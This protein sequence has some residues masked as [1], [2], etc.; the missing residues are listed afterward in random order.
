MYDIDSNFEDLI[1]GEK[2]FLKRGWLWV[3]NELELS[4]LN[5]IR[6]MLKKDIN[7]LIDEAES[8][9]LNVL[10]R[11]FIFAVDKLRELDKVRPES[12]SYMVIGKWLF[13][14]SP[15]EASKTFRLIVEGI[16]ESLAYSSKTNPWKERRGKDKV[17]IVYTKNFLNFNEVMSVH[18]WLRSIGVKG[19]MYYK[20][21][22]FTYLEI[23]SGHKSLKS[24]IYISRV[25]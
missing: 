14:Q 17:I 24:Y 18:D 4:S 8:C 10:R 20:P 22:L 23:Y 9:G 6:S 21:D 13:Y 11:E 3:K 5:E 19:T 25:K 2:C 16:S 12:L 15:I 7:L 1:R